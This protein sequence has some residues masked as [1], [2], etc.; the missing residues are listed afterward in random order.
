M[1]RFGERRGVDKYGKPIGRLDA[2]C[3]F[4]PDKTSDSKV[5]VKEAR[6]GDVILLPDLARQEG[7]PPSCL[8]GSRSV[9]AAVLDVFAR[10]VTFT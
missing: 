10:A 5:T 1:T 4:V 7:R 8:F 2:F 6:E 9:T 3:A